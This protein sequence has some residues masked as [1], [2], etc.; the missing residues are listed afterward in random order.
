[1][2]LTHSEIGTDLV[3]QAERSADAAARG[4]GVSV[5]TLDA[6]DDLQACV[7]LFNDVW[8]VNGSEPVMIMPIIRA[9]AHSG[10]YIAGAFANGELVGA[11]V[12]FWARRDGAPYLHSHITGVRRGL[13]GR[14]IGFALKQHQRAWT[15]Y[16]GVDAIAWTFDPLVRANGYFNLSKLGAEIVGYEMNF[17]GAMG[18]GI[19]FDD[20]SDRCLIWWLLS[21]SRAVLAADGRLPEPGPEVLA[22]ASVALSEGSRGRPEPRTPDGDLNLVYVPEDVVAMRR[23]DQNK[24]AS[25]RRALRAT[26]QPALQDGYVVSGM[27]RR[28]YYLLTKDSSQFGIG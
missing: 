2:T 9:I 12:G 21:S 7:S 17:Y 3:S 16:Q 19:N 13:Q 15:L 10:N 5:L 14:S 6:L 26:L 24:A 1:M 25:W 18:D 8:A 20:D 23:R 4:A 27:T 22:R 28:G 11:S